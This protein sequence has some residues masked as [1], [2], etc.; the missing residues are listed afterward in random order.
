MQTRLKRL[1]EQALQRLHDSGDIDL[2]QVTGKPLA[3]KSL[4]GE[5]LAEIP[6]ERTR[7]GDHG[8]F[9]SPIA[10]SLARPLRRNPREI[11]ESIV[12]QLAENEVL[13]K[14]EVAGA[15]YINF[16]LAQ[17]AIRQTVVDVISAAQKYGYSDVA[18]GVRTQV[19]FVSANPTGPLH[20]GH[21]RG[22]AFGAVLA[23]V[24][25]AA[26]HSVK[27]EYYVNDAGRQMDILA[28]SLWL[29]YLQAADKE[30][31]FPANAY[32]G[33]YVTQ[34]AEGLRNI[35]GQ[36]F[37]FAA[38]EVYAGI[39]DDGAKGGGDGDDDAAKAKRE[40]HIDA[41][42][43]K[44]KSLLGV[45]D[46][47][48]VFD[49]ALNEQV[50]DIRGDLK[51][52]GVE[53]DTWFSEQSLNDNQDI[54]RV[55]DRLKQSGDIYDVQG[56]LWFRSSAYGDE[57]DRVVV[58]GNGQGTYFAS[59]IAYLD[60]KFQRGFEHII[61][62]WGADH[63]GYVAR[64][65]AACKA[66]GHP[67]QNVE[68]LLVQF[69][70]LYR[71]GEKVQMSTRSGEFVTLRELREEVGTDAARFFYVMRRC[72]QH[73]DFDLDLARSQ[74]SDNPVYYL[75]YAHARIASIIEQASRQELSIDMQA[76]LA[77]LHLLSLDQEQQVM[78]SLSRFPE[79]IHAAAQSR[80]PHQICFYLRELAADFHAYYTL[81]DMKILCQDE[82]LRHARLVLCAAVR[83]VLANGLRLLGVS[84]PDK[85]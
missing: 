1:I 72:Q 63:H 24:L 61:Y 15:G 55:V 65:L 6:L 44:A 31:K 54:A 5:L 30:I 73:L 52:F 45:Q 32:K 64:L 46:Y 22:A 76:G 59:D 67:V 49:Y 68:I 82:H 66:L 12:A 16:Y 75:Q 20:V 29:R 11:A 21:G 70:S 74:V 8:D 77:S 37:E 56:T 27:R 80:E 42:I 17:D 79:I 14:I 18:T 71:G 34:M 69:A 81:R 40:T 25:E 47:K 9:A 23:N 7:G 19:E 41:L 85:M 57:K 38:S 62:V 33:T 13:E 4:A 36:R 26:G 60:N 3:G 84:A 39:P 78:R 43:E 58:R 50:A 10:L 2:S 28:L 35:H 48:V 53:F 51:S 83:Q